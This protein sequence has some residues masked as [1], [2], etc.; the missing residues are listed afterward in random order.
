MTKKRHTVF[1]SCITEN[2]AISVYTIYTKGH[3]RRDCIKEA[4]TRLGHE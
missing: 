3:I 4:K 2:V 1:A